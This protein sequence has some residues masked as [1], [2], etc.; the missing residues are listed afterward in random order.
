M[1]LDLK[2]RSVVVMGGSKGI[3]LACAQQFQQEGASVTICARSQASVDQGLAHLHNAV[4]VVADVTDA[5]DLSRVFDCAEAAFGKVDVLVVN[6]GG[7]PAGPLD[8][9]SD[10]QWRAAVDLTLM[11]AVRAARLA[12][13]G[14]RERRWGRI[15]VISS[16]GV[17]QP[18]PN[19]SLSNSVRMAVLGWAKT[20]ATQVAVDNVTVNTVC[21]GWTRTDRVTSLLA[22]AADAAAMEASIVSAIPLGRIGD[23]DEIARLVVFLGSEAA[24]YMT[25]TAIQVDGGIVQGYA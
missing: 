16:F 4:G 14:M 7:P 24:S 11:S 2:G 8:S 17:K 19:L 9:L 21:P 5:Q 12:L 1:D 20:L 25:G 18:A 6:A 10:D 3:G 23:A 15:V 22:D 13:P